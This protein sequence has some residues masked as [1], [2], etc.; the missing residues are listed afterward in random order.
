M[1]PGQMNARLTRLETDSPMSRAQGGEA[2]FWV[3]VAKAQERFRQRDRTMPLRAR[4]ARLSPVEHLAWVLRFAE[5]RDTATNLREADRTS[6]A[7]VLR[8]HD[9][10][11]PDTLEGWALLIAWIPG[12]DGC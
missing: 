4:R 12:D 10:A 11:V 2:A 7:D 9:R 6:L 1:T 3:A 5:R 8:H